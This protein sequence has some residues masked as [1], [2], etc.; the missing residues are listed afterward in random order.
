M[1]SDIN[2]ARKI[3]MGLDSLK[4]RA[5]LYS[6]FGNIRN[7]KMSESVR[8]LMHASAPGKKLTKIG[9]FLFMFP[10]PTQISNIVGLPMVGVGKWLDRYY[11]GVTLKHVG[12]ET[13]KTMNDLQGFLE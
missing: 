11:S 1:S 4:S 7:D 10:E 12:A 3:T 8:G 5:D 9:W 13:K 2:N 6:S